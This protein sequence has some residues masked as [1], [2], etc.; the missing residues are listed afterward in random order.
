MSRP[1]SAT[2]STAASTKP[3]RAANSLERLRYLLDA[4]TNPIQLPILNQQKLEQ[5]SS[6]PASILPTQTSAPSILSSSSSL[7]RSQARLKAGYVDW[8]DGVE[9]VKGYVREGGVDA[10]KRVF[11]LLSE[12]MRVK[13]SESRL[14]CLY[15][16]DE[17]FNRSAH[18]RHLTL[19]WLHSLFELTLG[20]TTATSAATQAAAP[21]PAPAA[22]AQQLKAEFVVVVRRWQRKWGGVHRVLELG[23]KWMMDVLGIEDDETAR[24][25]EEEEHRQRLA[26]EAEVTRLRYDTA[27]EEWNERRGE[28]QECIDS[29]D[30]CI[31]ILFPPEEEWTAQE[32]EANRTAADGTAEGAVV[33]SSEQAEGEA[34]SD[35]DEGAVEWEEDDTQQAEPKIDA[36]HSADTAASNI[37]PPP[38]DEDDWT[39]EY[40]R[41]GGSTEVSGLGDGTSELEVDEFN[42]G[43]G[44]WD[45]DKL[46]ADAGL[47][48]RAY[49][50]DINFDANLGQL[51]TEGQ[52]ASTTPTV[53]LSPRRAH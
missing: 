42:G 51:E 29:V 19:Q 14:L 2:A 34:A 28:M 5:S 36:K 38:A 13:N 46:V 25:R 30:G 33:D 37:E 48:S 4:L 1:R 27:R 43:E 40:L 20:I 31:E 50:L 49:E 15:L 16:I 6:P 26:R 21:L 9:Q 7:L 18:F 39:D 12:R 23:W 10:A 8:E 52:P 45:V 3:S 11:G 41:T 47:G 22:A 32:T 17:L 24:R 53:L 44:E 35:A